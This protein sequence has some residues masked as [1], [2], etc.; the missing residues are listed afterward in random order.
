MAGSCRGCSS[1]HALCIAVHPEGKPKDV[2]ERL[3][4][5]LNVPVE[6]D[7]GLPKH[8]CCTCVRQ[9]TSIET[10]LESLSCTAQS[11]YKRLCGTAGTRK[12]PQVY[13]HTQLEPDLYQR[14]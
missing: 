9:A 1:T 3:G 12:R 11:I 6:S 8:A 4:S 5:L 14:E 10:K 13:L 2:V 7:D